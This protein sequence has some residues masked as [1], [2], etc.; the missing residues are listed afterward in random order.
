MHRDFFARPQAFDMLTKPRQRLGPAPIV[1]R[2][3]S[4]PRPKPVEISAKYPPSEPCN[5]PRQ[6]HR[7]AKALPGR[8]GRYDGGRPVPA[9]PGSLS[10]GVPHTDS[11][12]APFALA[13]PA[14]GKARLVLASHAL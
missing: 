8:C 5:A 7:R 2:L 1:A 13:R 11:Y 12:L 10:R 9:S 4:E 3:V 14:T 6:P